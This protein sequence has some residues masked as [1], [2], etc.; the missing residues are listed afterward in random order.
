MPDKAV[1]G[2]TVENCHP[3][4]SVHVVKKVVEYLMSGRKD[5]EDFW[6]RMGD[7]YVYIRYFAVRT[8]WEFLG[9]WKSARISSPSG[10]WRREK[11]PVR[12]AVEQL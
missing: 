4:A 8:K 5:N 7:K 6:I 9:T 10:S 12:L 2:R 3:P 1:I 11:A